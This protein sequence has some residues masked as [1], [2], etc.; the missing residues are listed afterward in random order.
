MER[1]T[2]DTMVVRDSYEGW[3][4]RNKAAWHRKMASY[5]RGLAKELGLKPGTFKVRS[6]EAGPAILGEVTLHA[7]T[8]Y[9]QVGGSLFDNEHLPKE[10]AQLMY[11]SCNGQKDYTGG[12]NQWMTYAT[13]A[14]KQRV[15]EILRRFVTA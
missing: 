10:S 6:N 13:L 14:D 5:L 15:L 3:D 9:I 11:R 4:L 12:Q 8:F 2:G 7:D 1:L